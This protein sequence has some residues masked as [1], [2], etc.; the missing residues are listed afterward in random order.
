MRHRIAIAARV[1]L[2]SLLLAACASKPTIIAN[3]DPTADFNNYKTFGFVDPLST[4]KAGMRGVLSGFL[5]NATEDELKAR[6]LKRAYP[7][8]DLLIDFVV[9]AQQKIRSNNTSASVHAGRGGYGTWGGYG[10]AVSTPTVTQSTEGTVAIDII[11]VKRNQL[12]W[13]GAA[14]GRV[15]EDTRENLQYVVPAVVNEI[16]AKYPV[17]RNDASQ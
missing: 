17:P 9:S 7:D 16:F 5:I 10:M 4:D 3:Q 11:D 15:T 14:I 2:L 6:G 8:P 13:E 1:I 12:V